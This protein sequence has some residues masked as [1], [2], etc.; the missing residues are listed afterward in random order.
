MILVREHLK[1]Y[2]QMWLSIVRGIKKLECPFQKRGTRMVRGSRNQAIYINSCRKREGGMN[3]VL[4]I[5]K[6][7]RVVLREALVCVAPQ[8]KAKTSKYKL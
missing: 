3:R 4:S 8:S 5:E 6:I 1:L 7:G 2:T